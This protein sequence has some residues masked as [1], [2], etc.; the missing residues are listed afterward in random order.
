MTD[1]EPWEIPT[2]G[3]QP[4]LSTMLIDSRDPDGRRYV[5]NCSAWML[6]VRRP[7]GSI[8][9]LPRSA[10]YLDDGDEVLEPKPHVETIDS[11]TITMTM[12]ECVRAYEQRHAPRYDEAG[13]LLEPGE[14]GPH[15]W[16]RRSLPHDR[17]LWLEPSGGAARLRVGIDDGVNIEG[18]WDYTD[19]AAAWRAALGWNGEGDPPDGW[20]RHL[21]TARRRKDGTVAT[22]YWNAAEAP[23]WARPKRRQKAKR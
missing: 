4:L 10:A 13:E 23:P 5:V 19:Y 22:E 18:N 14:S 15:Y 3:R 21:E 20:R 12:F 1:F 16:Y 17:V 7:D 6:L 8:F 2:G 9:P 11:R